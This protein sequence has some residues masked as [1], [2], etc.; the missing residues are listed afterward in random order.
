MKT[1]QEKFKAVGTELQNIA[2]GQ[3][4][5]IHCLMLATLSREHVMF[6]GPPGCNKT[7]LI[8]AFTHLMGCDERQEL[9]RRKAEGEEIDDSEFENAPFTFYATLDRT[10]TPEALVGPYSPKALVDEDKWKRNT[11]NT[12]ID[13]HFAALEEVLNANSATLQCLH[14][15][16][17]EREFENAGERLRIPL[18]SC[19]A[20]TNNEAQETVKAFYDRFLFRHVVKY[21]GS[22]ERDEFLQMLSISRAGYTLP[23]PMLTV[24]EL[25]EA[26]KEVALIT[27]DDVMD[28]NL[29]DLRGTMMS[30]DTGYFSNRRWVKAERAMQASAWLRSDTSVQPFDMYSALRFVLW[31][32]VDVRDKTLKL[33]EKYKQMT[34][35]SI[36]EDLMERA[37]AIFN[38]VKD[39]DPLN[40][41][42]VDS[43]MAANV[44]LI[45]LGSSMKTQRSINRVKDMETH[46]HE[47]LENGQQ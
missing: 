15:A 44:E 10:T 25:E 19:F 11:T 35:E 12:L 6:I 37:E 4:D 42:S 38:N 39:L 29:F 18:M 13:C 40:S 14:R 21:I 1:L 31:D 24:S 7:N 22:T 20:A 27:V 3:N 9:E 36:E 28:T 8:S 2:V 32:R 47:L 33:L 41:D 34:T 5:L 45:E 30:E 46:V 17:N 26:Q 16:L 23:N 43:L